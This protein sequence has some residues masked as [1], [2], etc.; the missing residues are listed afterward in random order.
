MTAKINNTH[1]QNYFSNMDICTNEYQLPQTVSMQ[2][3]KSQVGRKASSPPPVS[4]GV[5]FL[6]ST[7][8]AWDFSPDLGI[9]G[10]NLGFR[11]FFKQSWDFCGS[12]KFRK[13]NTCKL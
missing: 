2:V 13:K 11:E 4:L 9:S 1:S 3:N 10:S 12:R 7:A 5:Y 6:A 8:T